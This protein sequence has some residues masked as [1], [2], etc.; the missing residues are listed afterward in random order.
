GLARNPA[1]AIATVAAFV[2]LKQVAVH[3]HNGV[4]GEHRERAAAADSA[5][6]TRSGTAAR[7]S[8]PTAPGT[9]RRSRR[10]GRTTASSATTAASSA[11]RADASIQ[12]TAGH[13]EPG[14]I[15]A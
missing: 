12:S 8:A 6:A 10:L 11:W 13:E 15:Q 4:A 2:G 1:A 5:G 9:V 14:I 3:D 7:S